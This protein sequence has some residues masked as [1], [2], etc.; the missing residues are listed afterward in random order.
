[1]SLNSSLLD[2]WNKLT[3]RIS[4][5]S[6]NTNNTQLEK[7][8]D[9]PE[10]KHFA[11]ARNFEQI[12]GI[13]LDTMPDPDEVLKK[14]GLSPL[15]YRDVLTDAHVAG[16]LLQR[17]SRTKRMNWLF[18][19]GNADNPKSVKAAEEIEAMFKAIKRMPEVVNEILEAP[20]FGATYLELFWDRDMISPSK[21]TGAIN[22]K[23]I[24]AK[25][26]EWFEWSDRQQL[27]LKNDFLM[28]GSG[29]SVPDYKIYPCVKDS[30]YI[31][32]YGDRNIKRVYWPYLFKKGGFRFWTEFIE[33]FGSPF[34]HGQADP[35][36]SASEVS[37]LFNNLVNMV[38]AGVIVTQNGSTK[39]TINVIESGSK[40][41]STDTF[42]KYKNALNIEI[43]KA[44][45]GET[46]TIENS[47][48]GSQAATVTHSEVLEILQDEDR[49]MVES[50]LSG[51]AEWVCKLNFGEGVESPKA[52]LIDPKEL[53][54]NI[55]KRDSILVKDL[56]V[57]FTP[58][59]ISRTYRLQE[60]DFTIPEVK[61]VISS[62]NNLNLKGK[63]F[64]ETERAEDFSLQDSL[65]LYIQETVS[66]FK[67]MTKPLQ[68]KIST[69]IKTSTD[70][71]DFSVK[72]NEL[73]EQMEP[74]MY[75][76]VFQTALGVAELA[77]EWGVN[78]DRT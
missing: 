61:Q 9:A 26:Y 67:D 1:M 50:A 45:L 6:T 12:T 71:S 10:N 22:L 59:Y 8:Q 20:L 40:S 7:E 30:T 56:G 2:Y 42:S 49:A 25:P 18:K 64:S 28:F 46:L 58:E 31:N 35:S 44:I 39:D 34:L 32:P 23:N 17:K 43:S 76:K 5:R 54:E 62:T 14:A 77:G 29:V 4:A 69:A 78:T 38:R 63:D 13:M 19:A 15:V 52:V 65:D 68:H 55:A 21:P 51:I 16:C 73:V 41:G 24:M 53:S 60:G 66:Q 75:A 47:E 57:K 72:M 74:S 37:D 70:F 36:K 11:D 3:S 27:K 48:S 33:K